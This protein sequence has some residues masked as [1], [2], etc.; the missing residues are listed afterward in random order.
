MEKAGD[1]CG[2]PTCLLRAR[3]DA[4]HSTTPPT[5]RTVLENGDAA[6]ATILRDTVL[7]KAKKARHDVHTFFE[8]VMKDFSTRKPIKLAPH[9]RLALDFVSDHERV[10]NMWAV[11]TSKTFLTLGLTLYNIG[12]DPSM[13]GAVVSASEEIAGKL[14]RL[15][16]DYIEQSVEL[17]LVFPHLR[18]TQ[19][20]G[21]PWTQTAITIDRPPGIKDATLTAYGID[22]DRIIGSRLSW[23]VVDDILNEENTGTHDQREKLKSQFDTNVLSRLDPSGGKVIITNTPW[24]PEDLVHHCW[25]RVGWATLRMDILGDIE[26]YDDERTEREAR[27]LGVDFKPWDSDLLRPATSDPAD[28]MCRLVAHDPDPSNQISL[29]PERYS[30]AKIDELRRSV[31]PHKFNQLYR[32]LAR[33]DETARCKIEYVEKCLKHARDLGIHQLVSEYKG[34]HNTYTGIDL[35]ISPGEEH[36]DTAFFT[37]EARPGGVNVILDIDIGQWNGPEILDKLFD[38]VSRF[39]S[40]VRVENVAA[41]DYLRQFALQRDLSIPIKGH[42]TEM[43]AKAHPEHGVEGLFVEMSNGA[44]AFPNTQHGDKHP[45]MLKFI[46]DCLN[47]VPSKHTADGLMACITPG[48]MITTRRGLVPVESVVAGDE[49]LTH[50]N[51]WRPVTETMKRR[52]R[53]EA[54]RIKPVGS[55][56]FTVTPEHP[57]WSSNARI[58]YETRSNRVVPTPDWDFRRADKLH[59]GPMDQGHFF[60]LPQ[61]PQVSC[62]RDDWDFNIID[63][64]AAMF[65]GLYLA[66]GSTGDHQVQFALH[67]RETHLIEFVQE[68]SK[69]LFDANTSI[70]RRKGSKGVVVTINSAN[71][72]R[73][74]RLC[75]KYERKC[76]PWKTW[77]QMPQSQRLAMARGWMMGDGC[78]TNQ[79]GAGH[80]SGVSISRDL[81]AQMMNPLFAQGWLPSLSSF[82]KAG[83]RKFQG[84]PSSCRDSWRLTLTQRDT[85]AFLQDANT[86]EQAHWC[87]LGT[88]ERRQGVT[89]RTNSRMLWTPVYPLTRATTIGR[90]PYDGWVYNF[91]VDEDESYCVEGVAVHNCY[92]ARAQKVEWQGLGGP[93]E[94]DPQGGG[95]IG[96]SIMSR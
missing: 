28:P 32:A 76:L 6:L 90:V 2:D 24:H 75:D 86:L 89:N 25:K 39:N 93:K 53:G 66:E 58:E 94:G 20:E 44:W 80:L 49:V 1:C 27:E 11:G 40:V 78:Y 19:R 43:R 85:S 14:L 72:T 45:M 54:I 15:V 3:A 36:D 7:A 47:Y 73:L 84:R 26:L 10:V 46:N 8:F 23:I 18:R 17:R 70:H 29:W 41:Q 48:A 71:A 81:L 50:K 12:N 57:V 5:G 56:A 35:A 74:M 62:E 55:P 88:P 87:T 92:F 61:M 63:E 82:M 33:A 59:A 77:H 68:Q 42:T 52:Y 21:E 79:R 22:S 95:N 64:D 4:Y 65:L 31:L 38:K 13:R 16:R 67:R 83:P 96:A 69:R 30:D 60:A 91:H 51:R 37:F 9:Q 34:P